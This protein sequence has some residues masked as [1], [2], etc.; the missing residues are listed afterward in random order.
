MLL[1]DAAGDERNPRASRWDASIWRLQIRKL[2]TLASEVLRRIELQVQDATSL[3]YV[4]YVVRQEGGTD[5]SLPGN[6]GEVERGVD[7]QAANHR[8]SEGG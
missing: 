8:G 7:R 3:D 4:K 2:E 1:G 5:V 6:A